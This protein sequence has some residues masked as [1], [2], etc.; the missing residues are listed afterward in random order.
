MDHKAIYRHKE[1]RKNYQFVWPAEPEG[2]GSG[3]INIICYS[4]FIISEFYLCHTKQSFVLNY[5]LLPFSQ[6]MASL[7]GW[8]SQLTAAQTPLCSSS[9]TEYPHFKGQKMAQAHIG[10]KF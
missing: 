10:L 1:K 2:L 5:L 9:D 7:P 8:T 4:Y 3:I 6:K